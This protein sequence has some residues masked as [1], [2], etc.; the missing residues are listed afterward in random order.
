MAYCIQQIMGFPRGWVA[1]LPIK[2]LQ[3]ALD[4]LGEL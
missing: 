3:K 4:A 2:G 1:P